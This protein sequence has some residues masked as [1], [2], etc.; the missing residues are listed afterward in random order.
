M[1]ISSVLGILGMFPHDVDINK[2]DTLKCTIVA[3]MQIIKGIQLEKQRN[4]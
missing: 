2:V 3:H 4:S 1:W